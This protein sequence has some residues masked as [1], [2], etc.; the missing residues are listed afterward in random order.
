M[1]KLLRTGAVLLAAAAGAAR[2]ACTPLADPIPGPIPASPYTV[3]LADVVS[4]LVFPVDV[5]EPPDGSGRLFV[6]E[7]AGRVR[8]IRNGTLLAPPFLDISATTT[9]DAGSA[10]SS[11]AF[12]PD[13]AV[14][15]SAGE[16]KLYTVSQEPPG[17]G[18]ADFGAL[19]PVAHQSVVYEW[20]ASASNP[21]LVDPASRREVLRVNSKSTVH[22]VDELVFGP[23]R[24]LYLSKGDDDMTASGVIDGTQVDGS[25]L[26]ID[27]SN[28]G[29][30]GK[31]GVPAGNP[32]LGPD[33]RLDELWAY[34]FRNPWRLSFDRNNDL[35][36]ATDIGEDDIEEVD[37][38]EPGRYYGWIDKEGRFA[39]L[40]FN[41]VTNDPSCLPPG[42]NGAD[43][44]AQYDHSQGDQSITGGVV[45]R[46]TLLR[47]LIG[48]YIFSD[49]VSGRL[50]EMAPNTGL[51]RLLAI[52]AAGA[53]LGPGVITVAEDAAGELLLVTGQ[54][55]TPTGR[56][57]RVVALSSTAPPPPPAVPGTSGAAA[58]RV[59]KLDATGSSLSISW[60]STQC[61]ARGYQFLYGGRA[62]LPASPGGSYGLDGARCDIGIT[63]PFFWRNVPSAGDASGLLWWVIVAH[64]AASTE[65]SWGK[66]SGGAERNGPGPGGVSQQCGMTAKSVAS[67][68]GS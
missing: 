14:A 59:A 28:P 61:E 27:P 16:R 43:P 2:G 58:Q 11:L 48:H 57:T 15:G 45:Y 38:I 25:I 12:H 17:S 55:L 34:G 29:P 52:D 8:V 6:T 10:M 35:L 50:F 42:F 31:Y 39:F 53:A 32:F 46:G 54:T 65:G 1:R 23:D 44:I 20:R 41:G 30:N 18:V 40:D 36:Y 51:I 4:T 9:L 26:R 60:D 62:D 64:D 47:P 33:P 66:R 7:R 67:A 37:V 19:S 63:S 21:D 22:N 49:Y 56:L 3:R 13:F 24:Y 68:C 5:A